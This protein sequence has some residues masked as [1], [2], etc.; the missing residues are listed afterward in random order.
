MFFFGSLAQFK[1]AA[2][3]ITSNHVFG[4][5]FETEIKLADAF[6]G[7]ETQQTFITSNCC[8]LEARDRNTVARRDFWALRLCQQIPIKFGK[9]E[10]LRSSTS[11]TMN[12]LEDPDGAHRMA[13]D[14]WTPPDWRACGSPHLFRA[15]GCEAVLWKPPLHLAGC[16]FRFL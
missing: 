8:L 2:F 1:A 13:L 15:G 6:L 11:S 7:L 5:S 14:S 10:A 12:T 9:N 4:G 16:W 3:K